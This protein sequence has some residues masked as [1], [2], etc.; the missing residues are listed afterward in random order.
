[1]TWS[2]KLLSSSAEL[3]RGLGEQTATSEVLELSAALPAIL[4][5][6]LLRCW[7]TPF[8]SAALSSEIYRRDGEALHLLATHNT[9]PAYAEALR[10]SPYRPYPQSPIGHMVADKTVADISDITA[11]EVYTSNSI[12]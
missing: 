6:Y 1:M 8:A 3:A 2:S 12:E 11:E 10:R 4:S 7:R 9:P 5:L